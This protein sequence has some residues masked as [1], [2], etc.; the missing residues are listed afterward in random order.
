MKGIKPR[1]CF[2]VENG[3]GVR[4]RNENRPGY[5]KT[6]VGWIPEEW[7]PQSLGSITDTSQ[8][9]L[10]MRALN[11]GHTPLLRMGNIMDGQL[12]FK[13][14]AYVDIPDAVRSKYLIKKNDLLFNRTNSLEHVGKLGIVTKAKPAAFASYLIRFQL[15]ESLAFPPFVAYLFSA[16]EFR[17]RLKRLATPGVCQY[18]INQSDLKRQFVIPLPP[19]PEQKKIA[20]I[21]SIWDEAIDQTRK[22]IDA[23]KRRKKALMQVLLNGK[24]IRDSERD[25]WRIRRFGELVSPISRPVPRPKE[26]YLSIGLRSHGRGTFQKIVEEPEKVMMDTLYKVEPEDL[27]VNIT[28]AWEGAIAIAAEQDS[29]G[30]VSHRF[31]TYRIESEK[32]D[33]EFVRNLILSERFVWD[34]GLI[35]PGGAGRNRVMSKR[36]FMKLNVLV[37]PKRTQKKFG[38]V[39][40]SADNEIKT[41][42]KKCAALERQKRGLMQK[43]LTGEVRV[44]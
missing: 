13:N 29:G 31:P 10:S 27:I 33:F 4:D 39:L 18:N 5:K 43:L 28:F 11:G 21:L 2:V 30:L 20:K 32:A 6:K 22:L 7:E 38:Q 9:G 25:E 1:V 41:L 17:N 8:Y 37:P 19:L 34:L 12:S 3:E 44:K 23:K 24:L 36:D 26:S 40:S 15:K 14:L 42:E 35:S 16:T